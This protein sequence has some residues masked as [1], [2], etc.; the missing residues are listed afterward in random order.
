MHQFGVLG[1]LAG[2]PM[3]IFMAGYS[4]EQEME[5]DRDGTTLAVEAG[6]SYTGILQLF[7]EFSHL[8]SGSAGEA[9]KSAGP[10]GEA[11]RLS[12]GTLVGYL[13][14]HPPSTQR[15]ESVRELADE[16]G[17]QVQPLK[18]LPPKV[19][20]SAHGHPCKSPSC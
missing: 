19:K 10:L 2:L 6:Y 3:E 17:W 7:G 13:S 1:E 11:A 20:L 14:S 9:G 5:A 15:S 16:R 18:P 12:L 8:E 4:K